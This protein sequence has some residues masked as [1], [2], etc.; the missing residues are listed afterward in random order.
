MDL[1]KCPELCIRTDMNTASIPSGNLVLKVGHVGYYICFKKKKGQLFY[2]FLLIII[3][4]TS[5]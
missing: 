2:P 1:Q 3:N 5:E 4:I